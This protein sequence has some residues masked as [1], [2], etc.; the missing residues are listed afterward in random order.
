MKKSREEIKQAIIL[1][2]EQ[3][4]LSTQQISEK[5]MSNWSTVNEVLEGLK[6]EGKVREMVSADKAKIYQRIVGDTYFD[7]PISSDER[8]KFRT[9]FSLIIKKYKEINETPNKTQ[10]AKV[11]VKVINSQESGLS[12]L[13]T[14]WYL[15]G[16]IPLMI[17]DPSQD[18]QE[19]F[20][21]EHKQKIMNIITIFIRDNKDKKTKQI[22]KEQHQEYNDGLYQ[23]HDDFLELIEKNSWNND[24]IFK[25]LNEFFIICPINEEFKEV[26]TLTD[27]FI[28][29]VRKLSHF[30]RLENHRTKILL[31]FDALWKFIATYKFYETIS[32]KREFSDK[33][34]LN[35]YLGNAISVRK[36]CAE[37]SLSDL[38]SVYLSKLDDRE[39][40]LTPE[41]EKV[42]EIMQGWTGED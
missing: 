40:E 19:E 22:Q 42:R 26:F 27:R 29:T 25:L 7:I 1:A 14:V 15:Y 41:A 33:N 11:A 12:E 31:T 35:L 36:S 23:L 28:S 3:K 24:Q 18:Y 2:L 10:L 9:L 16:M 4:P 6:A 34:L 32:F 17:A 30:D 39:L 5:I 8:K 37:E 38:Y 13:P 21:F 20:I